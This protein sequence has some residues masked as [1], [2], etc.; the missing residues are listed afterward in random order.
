M[1]EYVLGQ[2]EI[3][4][5]WDDSDS[6]DPLVCLIS[7]SLNESVDEIAAPLT[8]CDSGNALVKTPGDYSY[9][10]SFEGL[11]AKAATDTLSW[12]D[13]RTKLRALGT[14]TWRITTTYADASTDIEYGTGFFSSLE[15]TAE[16]K[17]SITFS[18]SLIGSGSIV[19]VD[20]NAT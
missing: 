3:L 1:A 15:K 8:K 19:A 4:S 18:G 16:N 12:V 10:I 11:Y 6:Y 17:E 7:H 13:L 20:P 14:F 5:V 2:N 9:E